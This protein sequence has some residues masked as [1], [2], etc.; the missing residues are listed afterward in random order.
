MTVKFSDKLA[1]YINMPVP[2]SASST[3]SVREISYFRFVGT[4]ISASKAPEK[5]THSPNETTRQAIEEARRGINMVT[6]AD[7]KELFER[8]N[9]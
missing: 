4:T 8:L 5:I 9:D 2:T 6:C 3:A 7:R 1:D